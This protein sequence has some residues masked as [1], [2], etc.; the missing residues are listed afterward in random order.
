VLRYH[1]KKGVLLMRRP[2][3]LVT[4]ALGSLLVA[5]VPMQRAS[6]QVSYPAFQLPQTAEREFNFLLADAGRATSMVAQ[7]REGV[8]VR[9]QLSFDVGFSD[10]NRGSSGVHLLLGGQ[11]AYQML[12][13]TTDAP[14][15]MLFTA[16]VFTR[17]G[18]DPGDVFSVPFGVSLGHRFGLE[19]LMAI[20]PYVHPRLSLDVFDSRTDL[21]INFDVGVGFEATRSLSIR[22]AATLGDADG[23]GIAAAWT[24]LGLR[25]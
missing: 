8:G 10:I 7:W 19:G 16:G 14:I 12:R 2:L 5:A 22:A 24:P 13:P 1:R 21:N 23:F 4:V 11:F 17:A 20:T 25:R 9:S 3:F 6:A 18:S 15:D